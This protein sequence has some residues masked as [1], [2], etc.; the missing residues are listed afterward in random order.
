MNNKTK[1]S[2]SFSL[3][4]YNKERQEESGKV[5]KSNTKK[6]KTKNKDNKDYSPKGFF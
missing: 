5:T 6:R 4:Q 2:K 3:V 1:I